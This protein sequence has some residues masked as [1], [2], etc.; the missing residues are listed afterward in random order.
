MSKI[1]KFIPIVQHWPLK[2]LSKRCRYFL[3]ADQLLCERN[4]KYYSF[5]HI[6]VLLIEFDVAEIETFKLFGLTAR[7]DCG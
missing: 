3:I 1:T 4:A 5:E 2:L 6:F 7:F